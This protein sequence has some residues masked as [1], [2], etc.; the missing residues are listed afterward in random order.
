[1]ANLAGDELAAVFVTKS[2]AGQTG[3]GDAEL[4]F[5]NLRVTSEAIMLI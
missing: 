1:L 2:R 3:G 4:R 5:S